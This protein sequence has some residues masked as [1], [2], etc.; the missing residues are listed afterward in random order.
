MREEIE[1]HGF[2]MPEI[3]RDSS[4]AIQNEGLSSDLREAWP[5]RALCGRK[6]VDPGESAQDSFLLGR[7]GTACG[8]A[9]PR[10][11]CQ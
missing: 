8:L 11:R 3:K 5:Q 7:A 4:A 2:S 10:T 6:D 9:I 1:I